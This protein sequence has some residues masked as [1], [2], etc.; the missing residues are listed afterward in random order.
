MERNKGIRV[1]TVVVIAILTLFIT[2]I[3]FAQMSALLFL[4]DFGLKDGA[5]SAM[6]GV[7]F[8]VDPDLKMYDVTHEIPSFNI[9]EGAYRLKQTASYWPAGTVFVGV[10]DPGVGTERKPIVLK[11]KAG[12]YFVGPDNGLFSL[13]AEDMGIE[14]VRVIDTEKNR[15]P[16]S[17]KSYTFHGR[18]VFSYVGARLASGQL[19][20]EDVGPILQG[21]IVR[22]EYRKPTLSGNSVSGNIPVL[23]IQ[24]GNVWSNI[25][26]E[27]FEQLNPEFGDIFKIEIYQDDQLIYTGEAPFVN[28]FGDV[29][30]G[31]VLIYYN[32]MMEVSVAINM[33]SFADTY[34]VSSG[35]EWTI[36][37]TQKTPKVSGKVTDIDKYG[38]VHTDILESIIQQKEFEIGDIV[39]VK[40]GDKTFE[41]PFATV[42]GDVDRGKPLI[43][44]TDGHVQL[45]INYG[46]FASTYGL[47]VGDTV[48][49]KLKEKGTYKSELEIRH[50][51]R[52]NN[53]ADYDSDEVFAN[54][55]EVRLGNIGSGKLYRSSHPSIND[56]RAPYASKLMES[57]G[58]KTVINL[59][60]SQEELLKNLQ[61]SKYYKSIYDKGD[62]IA[63]N[64]GVDPMSDDFAKKL[65]AGLVFMIQK[66]PPYLLHCVEGKDR[67]G[68]VTALLGAIMDAS[69][70][71]IYADYVKSYEN[72]YKVQPGTAAYDAVR[73]IISDLFVEMNG[74]KPVDD[75]NVKQV[76]MKY[77]TEKVG[78]T[79]QQIS[80]L[81]GKLK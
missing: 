2:S 77:L 80:Q 16:G 37:F 65:Q 29:P 38:N 20:F 70:E 6:K 9:W 75:S 73:K 55:R 60:D 7:A 30:E 10:V 23:D 53:R 61:Y 71:E 51:V 67:A 69:M 68:I 3:T 36:V 28:T 21:D 49:I 62:L 45:A 11:T 1:F 59:S 56:P 64:M 66:E 25:P 78:L 15:F 72:Y 81:Q 22:I 24:Y 14:E 33:E 39:Q 57:V 26:Y 63:L 31:D 40:I 32:S 52:T 8:G 5:V 17:E 4:T 44:L 41:A 18:D 34:G 12:Y 47:K 50:L 42:Y 48:T 54:F 76:A 74:G 43:R 27:L 46:N 35:P 19:E 79:A 58:I 13:V